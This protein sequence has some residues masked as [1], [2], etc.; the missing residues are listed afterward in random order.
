MTER[1]LNWTHF[2][3]VQGKS[4]EKAEKSRTAERQGDNR[5]NK[6]QILRVS[7]PRGEARY[8][9]L[10]SVYFLRPFFLDMA[11]SMAASTWAFTL[12]AE[13]LIAL[14][15]SVAAEKSSLAIADWT[16]STCA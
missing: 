9:R 1:N 6:P 2:A 3:V 16:P 15:L 12:S 8:P 5:G 11:F 4:G 13:D 10:L 14:A 7:D